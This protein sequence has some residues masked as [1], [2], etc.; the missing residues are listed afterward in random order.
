[1]YEQ[2]PRSRTPS[3]FI[4]MPGYRRNQLYIWCHK[5]STARA[6]APSSTRYYHAAPVPFNA[7]RFNH[8][9]SG[10]NHCITS[11]PNHAVAISVTVTRVSSISA[12]DVPGGLAWSICQSS[13]TYVR[14]N[15]QVAIRE[16]DD[17]AGRRALR[18]L[19]FSCWLVSSLYGLVLR[20]IYSTYCLNVSG[21]R[22]SG[23]YRC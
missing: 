21:R 3:T 13:P 20:S 7:M 17:R 18:R 14:A 2:I 8:C 15:C 1:M 10:T 9:V 16:C 6:S 11:S 5:L 12:S 22:L 23:Y 19:G 4:G